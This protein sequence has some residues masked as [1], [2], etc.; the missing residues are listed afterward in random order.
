M[1]LAERDFNV[2][3][4]NDRGGLFWKDVKVRLDEV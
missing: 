2:V 3:T 1:Q 4:A